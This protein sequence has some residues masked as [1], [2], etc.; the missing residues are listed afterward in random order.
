MIFLTQ[1]PGEQIVIGHDVTVTVVE[2]LAG[3]V[4]L[5]VEAPLRLSVRRRDNAART[6]DAALAAGSAQRQDRGH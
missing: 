3:R 2:V 6:R 5:G 1:K 4:R